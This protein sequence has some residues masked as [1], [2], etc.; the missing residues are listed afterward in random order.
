M[1]TLLFTCPKTRQQA[2]A[3]I[4]TDVQSLRAAWSRTLNVH[5]P[6]CGQEHRVSVRESFIEGAL[7]DAADQ[8][9][10]IS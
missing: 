9:R 10:R 5:C 2:S 8:L 7:N 3:G 4:G 1:A 6:L